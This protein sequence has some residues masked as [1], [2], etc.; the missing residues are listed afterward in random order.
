MAN[1][2]MLRLWY[3]W[4]LV[5][6]M[7]SLFLTVGRFYGFVRPLQVMCLEVFMV[8]RF[9]MVIGLLMGTRFLTGS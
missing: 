3:S 6:D 2:V 7:V 4:V 1:D 5:L 9:F 8:M